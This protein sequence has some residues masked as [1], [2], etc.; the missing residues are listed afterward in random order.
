[1]ASSNS[2]MK[3]PVQPPIAPM[4]AKLAG[5]IVPPSTTAQLLYEPKWD[6]FR[7]LIFRDADSVVI[8]SRDQKD[9]AYCFPE[10]V[11]ACADLPERI[12]LDGEIVVIHDG[13]LWFSELGQRVRP[14]SEAGGWKIR[15]L[16]EQS[17]VSYVAFD[18]LSDGERDL[19]Q[20]PFAQRRAILEQT[21]RP[22]T[23][24]SFYISPLT[25][26]HAQ[27][28]RWFH[29]FEGAGLDGV[30]CKSAEGTYTPDVRSML[31]V[32]HDRSV[33]VVIAGWRAHKNTA[34][35]GREMVGALLLGLYDSAGRLHNVGSSSAFTAAIRADMADLLRELTPDAGEHPWLGDADTARTQGQRIPGANSRWTG[36]KDLSFYPV[37][38]VLVAEVRY[39]HLEGEGLEYP[40]FRHS[41]R[42]V[43]WRPD[44]DATSCT[45]DQLDVAPDFDVTDV[46]EA[47]SQT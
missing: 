19:Q 18:I 41:A 17:P 40:R 36:K 24:P 21:M 34:A 42:F 38:P 22:V 32:K 35:D 11:A 25:D 7:A 14:R 46:L 30:V 5:D 6:G 13:R 10:L 1:M 29:T 31:K 8:Q 3:L 12:V 15:E 37:R 16:S 47:N 45:F 43:R 28:V 9:L 44:R 26:D 2:S 39:D 20:F 27:A 23:N 4:L 33:D